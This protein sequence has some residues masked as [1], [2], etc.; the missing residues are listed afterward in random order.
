M[1]FHFIVFDCLILSFGFFT[2]I[3]P[4]FLSPIEYISYLFLYYVFYLSFFN[5]RLIFKCKTGNLAAAIQSKDGTHLLY[6][7]QPEMSNLAFKLCQI[8]PKWDKS[9]TF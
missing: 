2:E 6:H 9:G 1:I 3:F 4:T 8:G 7:L 5:L